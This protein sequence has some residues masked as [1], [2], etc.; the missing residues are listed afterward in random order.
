M[1]VAVEKY[2]ARNWTLVAAEVPGRVAKQCRDRW[3]AIN[4]NVKKGE[5]SEEEDQIILKSFELFGK[6]WTK[7]LNHIKYIE[8]TPL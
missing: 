7:V 1:K 4:P 8:N 6:Q 2:G 5:W 3:N